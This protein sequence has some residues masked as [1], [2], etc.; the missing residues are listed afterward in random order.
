MVEKISAVTPRVTNMRASVMFY[1]GLV[2]LGIVL[3]FSRV[4]VLHQARNVKRNRAT[5]VLGSIS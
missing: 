3:P 4:L 1:T 2:G 5:L